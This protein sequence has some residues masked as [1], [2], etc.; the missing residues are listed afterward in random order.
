MIHYKGCVSNESENVVMQSSKVQDMISNDKFIIIKSE[1]NDLFIRNYRLCKKEIKDKILSKISTDNF[2]SEEFDIDTLKYGNEKV[3]IFY[4]ECK[5][6][7]FHGIEK[8]I[9]VYL[10]IKERIDNLITISIHE[11]ER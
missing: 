10:K 7:D 9:I 6:V 2:I 11:K 8:N 5:L 3:A 1:K 4:V